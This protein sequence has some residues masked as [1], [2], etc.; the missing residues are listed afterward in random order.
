MKVL[1]RDV[2]PCEH[3]L[4]PRKSH[5]GGEAGRKD[6]GKNENSRAVGGLGDLGRLIAE[7]FVEFGS[8]AGGAVI[9]PRKGLADGVLEFRLLAGHPKLVHDR[10]VLKG[11]GKR[12][13]EREIVLGLLICK[14]HEDES[15]VLV[16]VLALEGKAGRTPTHG[17][18][19]G[20]FHRNP[21]MG[22][23]D[24]FPDITGEGMFPLDQ[25]LE[26]LFSFGCGGKKGIEGIDHFRIGGL[27]ILA[28]QVDD[29]VGGYVTIYAHALYG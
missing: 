4:K 10:I 19:V 15:D 24:S 29:A 18:G 9:S 13:E 26:Y 6:V 1:V 22:E 3:Q 21:S 16:A 7:E 8:A 20:A 2:L 14:K 27:E 28:R 23:G 5:T 11:S 25:F 17:E 12:S